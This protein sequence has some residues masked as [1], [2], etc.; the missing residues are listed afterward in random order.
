MTGSLILAGIAILSAALSIPMIQGKV[1]RNYWY[2]FRTKLT[3]SSDEV[4]YPANRFGGK[5]ILWWSGAAFVTGLVGAVILPP[6]PTLDIVMAGLAMTALI[7][8]FIS[9][10]WVNKHFG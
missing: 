4:W 3:L 1:K 5:M 7:P 6:S 10:Y 8:C 9:I 2:G